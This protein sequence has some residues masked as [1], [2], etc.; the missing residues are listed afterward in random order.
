[1]KTIKDYI[2][3][4]DTLFSFNIQ[5]MFKKSFKD[6]GYMFLVRGEVGRI[7]QDVVQVDVHELVQEVS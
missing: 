5:L 4:K 7:Y 2:G 1:M 3:M 6:S